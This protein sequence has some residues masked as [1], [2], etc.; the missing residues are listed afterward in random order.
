M[1][2]KQNKLKNGYLK[3][4]QNGTDRQRDRQT[5]RKTERQKERKTDR[6]TS[7]NKPNFLKHFLKP[8]TASKLTVN[9]LFVLVFFTLKRISYRIFLQILSPIATNAILMTFYSVRSHEHLQ[10]FLTLT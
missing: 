7:L 2:K 1:Q 3:T 4:L 5:D 9:E 6:Q 8:S 10:A